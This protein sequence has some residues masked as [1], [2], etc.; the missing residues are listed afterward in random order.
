MKK[1]LLNKKEVVLLVM[2]FSLCFGS[3]AFAEE[4][5]MEAKKK[6]EVIYQEQM[7][8]YQMIFNEMEVT[9][10]SVE[11]NKTFFGKNKKGKM[12]KAAQELSALQEKYEMVKQE[13]ESLRM[14]LKQQK[15][16]D[17]KMQE[18]LDKMRKEFYKQQESFVEEE[19]KISEKNK[20]AV[21]DDSEMVP[22]SAPKEN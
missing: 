16:E 7:K 10:E 1:K 21:K 20:T 13:N 18:E 12:S 17:K 22:E 15:E 8:D 9:P 3:E 2:S 4:E 6:A 19:E 14:E 11:K 5:K